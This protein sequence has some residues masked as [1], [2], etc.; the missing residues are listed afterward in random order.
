[1]NTRATPQ[2]LREAVQAATDEQGEVVVVLL[3]GWW[4]SGCN[5]WRSIHEEKNGHCIICGT[6]LVVSHEAT[7]FIRE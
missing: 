4:C 6:E 1:M 3:Y 2:E 7:E 5:I